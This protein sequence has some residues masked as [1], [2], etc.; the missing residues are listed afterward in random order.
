[1][2]SFTLHRGVER[3]DTLGDVRKEVLEKTDILLSKDD[4]VLKIVA[5]SL[6]MMERAELHQKRMIDDFKKD[7]KAELVDTLSLQDSHI[8]K[9]ANSLFYKMDAQIASSFEQPMVRHQKVLDAAVEKTAKIIES[10]ASQLRIGY[11]KELG[12]LLSMVWIC[13]GVA[14]ISIVLNLIC[15]YVMFVL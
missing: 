4:P 9:A 15:L 13:L 6:N 11:Q 5:H 12:R 2:A 14:L 3:K 10:S 7:I 1:M 8:L